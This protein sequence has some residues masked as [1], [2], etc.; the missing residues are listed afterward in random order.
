ME[1]KDYYQTL[2][3][4][5]DADPKKIKA[6]YRELAF[7]FH[8]DRNS[9]ESDS[10]EQM[11]RVNEAYAVLSNRE[12]RD[13]YDALQ[14][15]FGSSAHG[16][17]R[18]SYSDED[19]FNGSDINSVF[20]EMAKSFGYRGFDEVF[21]EFYGQNARSFKFQKGGFRGMGFM[22]QGT[23]GGRRSRGCAGG[24]RQSVGGRGR[25]AGLFPKERT[26][27]LLSKFLLKKLS[28]VTL[29]EA[30]KDSCDMIYLSPEQAFTGGPYAYYHRKRDKKLVVK[31]PPGIRDGQQ[32]RLT[33]MGLPGKGSGR[34]GDHFLKVTI[35]TQL[36]VKLK[37]LA[38]T[39]KS[40]LLK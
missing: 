18:K 2:G 39:I 35:R 21:K 32:I 38:G 15:Q 19:I 27:G 20:E 30:G 1:H 26:A 37:N 17:F 4:E 6:A 10:A 14:A 23:F 22:F 11:K 28:G 36:S 5:K 8:P 24:R 33:A 12:K 3:V 34:V 40:R 29:P 25:R 7:K 31:V 9:D 16:Q 13:E